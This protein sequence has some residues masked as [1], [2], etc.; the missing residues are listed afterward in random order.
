MTTAR[1]IWLGMLLAVGAYLLVLVALLGSD[2]APAPIADVAT[3]RRA[4][5]FVTVTVVVVLFWL[6]RRLPL[7]AFGPDRP[8]PSAQDV[9]TTYIVCWALSESVALL[10]LVLG[11]LSRSIGE[12][13]PFFI[14]ATAL[15]VWQRPRAEHFV[16]S[17]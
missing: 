3:L 13:Y 4:L 7:A 9:S 15:L 16:A 11:L 12:A 2:A 1:I 6:R 14:V 10:G 17:A 5:M 8:T